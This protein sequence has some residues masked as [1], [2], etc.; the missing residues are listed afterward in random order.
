MG[1]FELTSFFILVSTESVSHPLTVIDPVL[2]LVII[3][4]P[5]WEKKRMGKPKCG[6]IF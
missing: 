4:P 5:N 3:T 6:Q 1:N 2:R